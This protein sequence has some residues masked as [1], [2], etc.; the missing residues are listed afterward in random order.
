MIVP[1]LGGTAAMIPHPTHGETL[2][3]KWSGGVSRA[4]GLAASG[5]NQA[6]DIGAARGDDG[7][8]FSCHLHA[9]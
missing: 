3:R 2:L 6:S 8:A 4:V 1:G 7:I 5:R 9:C